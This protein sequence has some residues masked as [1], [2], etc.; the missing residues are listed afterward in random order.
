MTGTSSA[1]QDNRIIWVKNGNKVCPLKI[2]TGLSD[3]LMTEI[4][5]DHLKQ[6]LQIV[7]GLYSDTPKRAK[8]DKEP[9]NPFIPDLPPPP[10]GDARPGGR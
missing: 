4:T 7:V 9:E 1:K 8:D 10:A 5:G 6:G 3:G 2:R